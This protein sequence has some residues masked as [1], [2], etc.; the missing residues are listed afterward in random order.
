MVSVTIDVSDARVL[1]E[2]ARREGGGRLRAHP[3]FKRIEARISA[4]AID[5]R[6][7]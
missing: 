4:C 1:L 2:K 3:H 6:C 7:D 5:E